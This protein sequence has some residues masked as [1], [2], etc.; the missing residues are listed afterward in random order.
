MN[1]RVSEMHQ[2]DSYSFLH[3]RYCFVKSLADGLVLK[4]AVL[5][6]AVMMGSI[7]ILSRLAFSSV[8]DSSLSK[9]FLTGCMAA[10]LHTNLMSDP[11]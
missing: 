9:T 4:M 6:L 8:M 5:T 7:T 10:S 1:E 11:E 2:T 3:W